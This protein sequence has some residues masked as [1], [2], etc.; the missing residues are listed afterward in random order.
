MTWPNW[1]WELIEALGIVIGV[2]VLFLSVN[3]WSR[4]PGIGG[5]HG[6]PMPN[7]WP[8]SDEKTFRHGDSIY[9]EEINPATNLP[10][11]FGLDLPGS[12]HAFD[13]RT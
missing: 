11:S 8:S 5:R 2:L 3:R 10:M 6:Y 7:T 4:K 9:L 13:D 1:N 12:S